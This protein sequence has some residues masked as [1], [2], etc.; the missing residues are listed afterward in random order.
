MDDFIWR[1]QGGHRLDMDKIDMV[2]LWCDGN[3]PEFQTRKNQ[4]MNVAPSDD[5]LVGERRYVDNDELKYSLRSLEK[6]VPWINHVYIVTDRQVPKW[7]NTDY[8]KVTVVDHSEIMP[9]EIIPVFNSVIIEYFLP[10]IPNLSEK[11]LYG[12]D[13]MFFGAPMTEDY[14]FQGDKPI[15]RLRKSKSLQHKNDVPSKSTRV[16]LN[17][18]KEV[19]GHLDWY[20]QHHNIDSFT[21][22]AYI[23]TLNR[24]HENFV[25]TYGNRF[26]TEFDINRIIFA[27]DAL[28]S[29]KSVLELVKTPNIFERKVLSLFKD[30]S[31]DS[32]IGN[33]SEKTRQNILKYKPKLFCVNSNPNSAERENSR[34]F[35]DSLFPAPSKF[36]K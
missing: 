7:L 13:D 2:Y 16:S 35:L 28:Y 8:E 15:L 34:R 31:W 18:L 23:E 3:D 12:N 4:Y 20:R 29:D 21:K 17:L 24:Y 22:S 33:E 1:N 30:V 9:K 19:H 14:F 32:L 27:L 11:F 6:Y 5:K 25:A 26:R 10:F 36:E